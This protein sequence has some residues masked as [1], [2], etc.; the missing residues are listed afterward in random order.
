MR[1]A[2]FTVILIIVIT[3]LSCGDT[4]IPPNTAKRTVYLVS[5]EDIT[6]RG[7][8]IDIAEL[9][10]ITDVDGETEMPCIIVY[11]DRRKS[12]SW[13]PLSPQY[14]KLYEGQIWIDSEGGDSE[15]YRIVVIK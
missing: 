2:I 14:Y 4:I 5:E 7:G 1:S 13:S 11:G 10:G 6:G 15:F 8:Y 12:D 9:A 3:F